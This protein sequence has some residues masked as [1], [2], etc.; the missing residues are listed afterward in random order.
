MFNVC[1]S[2]NIPEQ[3]LAL[4]YFILEREM[5]ETE[6]MCIRVRIMLKSAIKINI[7][8]GVMVEFQENLIEDGYL[9]QK[10]TWVF[11]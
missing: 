1:V 9:G 7:T 6:F 5:V 3:Y 10:L 11:K 4:V 8:R 2:I